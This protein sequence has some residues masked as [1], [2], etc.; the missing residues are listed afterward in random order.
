MVP[1]M[2]GL[3]SQNQYSKDPAPAPAPDQLLTG[4]QCV[5]IQGKNVLA[6]S[7]GLEVIW[8]GRTFHL[9]LAAYDAQSDGEDSHPLDVE[10]GSL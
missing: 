6:Q 10:A 7:R 3:I 9:M 8:I 5:V 2:Q 1:N 4:T